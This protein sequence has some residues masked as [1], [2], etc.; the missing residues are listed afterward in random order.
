MAQSAVDDY[1]TSVSENTLLKQQDSV[2]IRSLRQELLNNAL[3][4]YKNF[5]NQRSNDPAL[6]QQ[7]ANAYFRAGE[8]TRGNRLARVEAIEAFHSAQTIWEQLAAADPTNDQLR[9]NIADCHLAIGK[10]KG[11]IGDLQGALTSFNQAR[12]ILEPL[13]AIGIPTWLLTNQVWPTVSPKSGSSRGSSVP[14]I[15]ALTALRKQMR[16]STG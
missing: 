4:Y 13:A 15:K 12:D 8:I 7:L 6:R 1:L 16:Y 5:V 9:E 3:T 2:D 14:A 10:Q 11:A